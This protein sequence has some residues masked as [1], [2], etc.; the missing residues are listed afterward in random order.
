MSE[1]VAQKL[2]ADLRKILPG[3]AFRF[4][5]DPSQAVGVVLHV[6]SAQVAW[7]IDSY[8]EELDAMMEERLARG[9][10][11]GMRAE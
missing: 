8:V 4:E 7:T 3:L 5:V 10:D 9:R 2:K 1:P 11:I 6:G